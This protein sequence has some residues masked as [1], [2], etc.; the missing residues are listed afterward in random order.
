MTGMAAA[1]EQETLMPYL[2]PPRTP[3]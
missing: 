3:L 1:N 2:V